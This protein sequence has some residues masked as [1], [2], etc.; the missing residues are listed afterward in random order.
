MFF[1]KNAERLS[2]TKEYLS[3]HI[4]KADLG[5]LVDGSIILLLGE[6]GSLLPFVMPLVS[7]LSAT[8]L[9]KA[10][11]GTLRC[12][13]FFYRAYMECHWDRSCVINI[14]ELKLQNKNASSVS[15]PTVLLTIKGTMRSSS[16]HY[17]AHLEEQV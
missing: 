5:V 3:F 4:Q 17:F 16:N 12:P 1:S 8:P 9:S 15:S 7:F 14:P 2:H 6:S 10:S 13:A 11:R